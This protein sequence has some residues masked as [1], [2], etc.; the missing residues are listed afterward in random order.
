MMIT[1]A[2]PAITGANAMRFDDL[3]NRASLWLGILSPVIVLF[4]LVYLVTLLFSHQC[5]AM[6]VSFNKYE[7]GL[8]SGCLVEHEGKMV[9]IKNVVFVMSKHPHE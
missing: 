6:A 8:F 5:E 9:P 7:F 2:I 1:N 4:V 3:M